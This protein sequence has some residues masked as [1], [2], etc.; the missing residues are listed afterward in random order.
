MRDKSSSGQE[1]ACGTNNNRRGP[2]APLGFSEAFKSA[3]EGLHREAR[4]GFA[5]LGRERRGLP[6]LRACCL[7]PQLG[8]Q[9]PGRGS[10]RS[11]QPQPT[12]RRRG[13]GPYRHSHLA[14]SA[15]ASTCGG[16][17]EDVVS[18][19]LFRQRRLSPSPHPTPRQPLAVTKCVAQAPGRSQ[20]QQRGGKSSG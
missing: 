9:N 4:R 20:L 7:R 11:P 19:I 16:E 18:K 13:W 2:R 5:H 1:A 10:S 14:R 6:G 17:A 15:A 3:F 8:W 12:R